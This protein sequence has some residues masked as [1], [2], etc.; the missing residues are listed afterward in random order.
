MITNHK[1]CISGQ[2]ATPSSDRIITVVSPSTEESIGTVTEAVEAAAD[3]AVT[4]TRR[5]YDNPAGRRHIVTRPT[6]VSRR[7]HDEGVCLAWNPHSS[8][9]HGLARSDAD[10][11]CQPDLVTGRW[12]GSRHTGRCLVTPKRG[13]SS[14]SDTRGWTRPPEMPIRQLCRCSALEQENGHSYR[15]WYGPVLRGYW[16]TPEPTAERAAT[17]R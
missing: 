1:I 8:L 7:V 16:S 15:C 5:A 9:T 17:G 3:A 11:H 12:A 10:S 14:E 6:E 13:G 2:W 4:A